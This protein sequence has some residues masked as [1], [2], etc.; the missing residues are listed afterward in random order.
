MMCKHLGPIH[1]SPKHNL[2]FLRTIF[3]LGV[4]LLLLANPSFGQQLLGTSSADEPL[5]AT[6]IAFEQTE[7]DLGSFVAGD[8]VHALFRFK[9]TGE[10]DL[11]IDA[12]KASCPC[13]RLTY[14]E[15]MIKP[16]G[17]GEVQAAIDTADK[18]GEQ[19]KY[20]TVLFN[21][22]PP[23]ERVTL[24]FVVTKPGDGGD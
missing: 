15:G 12:V 6:T 22:N 9:N 17:M 10:A 7:Y 16:Q 21:G 5:D 18:E 4:A 14:P 19:V 8:T 23:V 20:F 3:S 2:N 24:R 1:S 13:A 11:L